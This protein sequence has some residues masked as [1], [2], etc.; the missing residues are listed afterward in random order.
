[1]EISDYDIIN[2]NEWLFHYNICCCDFVHE[3]LIKSMGLIIAL[4]LK[5]MIR[6][7]KQGLPQI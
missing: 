7:L 3:T 4:L 5:K 6:Y 1:M 2:E